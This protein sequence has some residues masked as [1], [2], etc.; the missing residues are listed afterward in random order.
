[1]FVFM[2]RQML[3]RYNSERMALGLLL[4]ESFDR[5]ILYSYSKNIS[6]E[7]A[8]VVRAVIGSFISNTV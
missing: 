1:M 7:K 8:N 5:Y 2:H 6:E 3:A 4:V